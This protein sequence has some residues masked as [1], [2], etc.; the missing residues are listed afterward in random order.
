M[1]L[2]GKMAQQQAQ[3]RHSQ[4]QQSAP[5]PTGLAGS[6]RPHYFAKSQSLSALLSGKAIS[7]SFS[8]ATTSHIAYPTP[9]NS[10]PLASKADAPTAQQAMLAAAASQTLLGKL[11]GAFWDA[12]ARPSGALGPNGH[13]KK[14]WDADKVRRVMEGTAVL[15]VVDVEPQPSAAKAPAALK[16]DMECVTKVTDI[17]AESMASLN[18]GR[19]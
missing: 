3:Q 19:K 1:H 2:W 10:P 6:I 13:V 11:G 5:A 8:S 16:Q 15:K 18:L 4:P 17:L 9:P 14:E 12:F 7:S